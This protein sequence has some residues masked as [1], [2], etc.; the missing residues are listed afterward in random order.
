MADVYHDMR[1]IGNTILYN[2]IIVTKSDVQT[3]FD[4]F[5]HTSFSMNLTTSDD[6]IVTHKCF[7]SVMYMFSFSHV[8]VFIQSCTCFHSVMYMF[9]FSHVH[10]F[11]QYCVVISF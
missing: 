10:V 8:H 5:M 9:S 4:R 7:S 2:K 6:R 11:I 1:Q 3:F